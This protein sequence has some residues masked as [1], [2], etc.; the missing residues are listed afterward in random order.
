MGSLDTST[1]EGNSAAAA[2]FTGGVPLYGGILQQSSINGGS[3]SAVHQHT[4]EGEGF[5]GGHQGVIKR[6]LVNP[7]AI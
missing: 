6:V 3:G 1:S 2:H 5:D 4:Q 7:G